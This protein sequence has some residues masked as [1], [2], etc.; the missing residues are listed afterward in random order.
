MNLTLFLFIANLVLFLYYILRSKH[1]IE[2]VTNKYWFRWTIF[3]QTGLGIYIQ[4]CY[5]TPCP[6]DL[7]VG[8]SDEK[9][10]RG[11]IISNFTKGENF[12][13]LMTTNNQVVLGV[14]SQ[15]GPPSCTL[16]KRPSSSL[17][18]DPE[19]NIPGHLIKR[20]AYWF[21]LKITRVFPINTGRVGIAWWTL[22]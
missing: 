12:S 17:Q 15:C 7:F 8:S 14:I 22:L 6:V 5:R 11:K 21:V 20:R 16:Q 9:Q 13:S 4:I 19:K 2:L 1:S 3:I 10:R 18:F